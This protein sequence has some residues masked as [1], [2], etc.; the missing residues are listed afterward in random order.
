DVKRAMAE[1]DEKVKHPPPQ[2][3]P[4]AWATFGVSLV[5]AGA[6]G[7]MFG[8]RWWRNRYR[9]L[10]AQVI[11][12]IESGNTPVLLD[13]RT[14]TDFET[15]PLRLPGAKRLDPEDVARGTFT[16]DVKPEQM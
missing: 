8:R 15:S 16:L 11:A 3:F 10:P 9:I 6:Y 14:Q 12:A 1:A 4:W 7:G 2:P 13:V 5:S